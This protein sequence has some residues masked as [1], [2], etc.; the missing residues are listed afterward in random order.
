MSKSI[1]AKKAAKKKRGERR[2]GGGHRGKRAAM[3][4]YSAGRSIVTPHPE[5]PRSSATMK[6][7]RD[8]I[9]LV[10]IESLGWARVPDLKTPTESCTL[11]A[12]FSD[13]RCIERTASIS[14]APG[15]R[16]RILEAVLGGTGSEHEV[17]MAQNVLLR[18]TRAEQDVR[19][20]M[21]S[22]FALTNPQRGR[23]LHKT[24][25]FAA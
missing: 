8:V 11:R 24:A 18:R 12:V 21:Q 3:R 16:E 25:A 15:E 13:G 5:K 6:P 7:R 17:R 9:A 19:G 1:A 2:A 22:T 4:D 23:A 20:W 10:R 14:Y